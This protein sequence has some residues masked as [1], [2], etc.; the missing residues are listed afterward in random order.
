M[1]KTESKYLQLNRLNEG[2]EELREVLNE[3]CSTVE[4][5]EKDKKRLDISKTLDELIVEYMKELNKLS[6]INKKISE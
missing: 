2:I 5:N 3:I 1:N 6:E 4:E